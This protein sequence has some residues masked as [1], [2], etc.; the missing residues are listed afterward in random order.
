MF[1]PVTLPVLCALCPP[2]L[3]ACALPSIQS[4]SPTRSPAQRLHDVVLDASLLPD[5]AMARNPEVQYTEVVRCLFL[6][7]INRRQLSIE[8]IFS[9]VIFPLFHLFLW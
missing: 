9:S 6:S 8:V 1:A 3:P 4:P 7:P 2:P 5:M